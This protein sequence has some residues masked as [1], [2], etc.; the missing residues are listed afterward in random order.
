MKILIQSIWIRAEFEL[1]PC[2]SFDI[3]CT[4]EW[5]ELE[6][7]RIRYQYKYFE[8]VEPNLDC[9][10]ITVHFKHLESGKDFNK[11]RV[12]WSFELTSILINR[13]PYL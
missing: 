13:M 6:T 8:L 2:N 1:K 11:L 4:H 12:K 7:L 9:V 5:F 10:R 3:K